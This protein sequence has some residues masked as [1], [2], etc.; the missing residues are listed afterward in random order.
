[1]DREL[2]EK[3]TTGR[4]I[5][6]NNDEPETQ[7]NA[8]TAEPTQTH[9]R[10]LIPAPIE[11]PF[12]MKFDPPI[13]YDGTTYTEI[14]CDFGKFIGAD[15]IRM[16]RE[17]RRT[18]KPDRDEIPLPEMSP[19][20][21]VILISEAADVPRGLIKKLP[22]RFWTPLRTEALKCCGSSAEE[23]KA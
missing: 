3:Q 12:R 11:E 14:V 16:Q 17:F 15:F 18:Y 2:L 22:G 20:Y 19:D 10:E 9:Y 13:Q 6:S 1:M 23:K 21:H 7:D 8:Q 4:P 5:S